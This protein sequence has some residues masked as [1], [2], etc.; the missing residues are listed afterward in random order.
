MTPS[1]AANESVGTSLGY[2][3]RPGIKS[4]DVAEYRPRGQSGGTELTSGTEH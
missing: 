3:L 2:L 1:I 4:V